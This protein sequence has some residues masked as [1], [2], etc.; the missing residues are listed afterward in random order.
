MIPRPSAGV[1]CSRGKAPLSRPHPYNLKPSALTT[2]RVRHRLTMEQAAL[3]LGVPTL[4]VARIEAS[5]KQISRRTRRSM[6]D[7]MNPPCR[8]VQLSIFDFIKDT[9]EAGAHV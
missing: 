5:T 7:A 8:F 3:K 1:D 9:A 4:Q 6:S 2:L